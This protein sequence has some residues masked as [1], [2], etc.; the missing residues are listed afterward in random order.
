MQVVAL[1]IKVGPF[2]ADY[3]TSYGGEVIMNIY[4]MKHH[5]VIES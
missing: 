1:V 3:N 4:I 2:T 5:S